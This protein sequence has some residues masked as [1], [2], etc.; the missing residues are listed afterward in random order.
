MCVI[1]ISDPVYLELLFENVNCKKLSSLVTVSYEI[2]M[3]S[4]KMFAL[5]ES[6]QA[7]VFSGPESNIDGLVY[8]N[9]YTCIK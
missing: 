4:V 6:Q 3:S 7:F 9:N 1:Y 5:N 2:N 8:I